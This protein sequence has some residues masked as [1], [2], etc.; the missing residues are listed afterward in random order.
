LPE[1]SDE[2]LVL[3]G[4]EELGRAVALPVAAADAAIAEIPQAVPPEKTSMSV[5]VKS[6]SGP[7]VAAKRW[8][9]IGPVISR[10]RASG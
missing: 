7:S 8:T 4:C 1:R 10:S 2:L 3:P 6:V 9:T 5:A